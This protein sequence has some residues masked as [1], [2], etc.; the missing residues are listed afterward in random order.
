M[1]K[2]YQ[3]STKHVYL[4][5]NVCLWVAFISEGLTNKVNVFKYICTLM[6][7]CLIIYRSTLRI[8]LSSESALDLTARPIRTLSL[9]QSVETSFKDNMDPYLVNVF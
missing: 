6:C 7:V 4:T 8:H 2:S 1:K 3:T 5:F 9:S